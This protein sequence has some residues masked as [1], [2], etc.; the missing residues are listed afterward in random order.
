MA[1]LEDVP[2]IEV[3]ITVNGNDLKEYEED[4]IVNEPKTVTKYIEATSGVNFGIRYS[5]ARRFPMKGDCITFSM[6]L[7]NEKCGSS[8]VTK[9]SVNTS[10]SQHCK[11]GRNE[12][13]SKLR[14]FMFA[15]LETGL[16]FLDTS[17]GEPEQGHG[18][19]SVLRTEKVEE[20]CVATFIFRYRSLGGSPKHRCC[21]RIRK[22]EDL[23][24]NVV[25]ALKSL[26][27]IGRTP[28]PVPLEERPLEELSADQLREIIRQKV[29]RFTDD[30]DRG[31]QGSDH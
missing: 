3:A 19:R 10:S 27:I 28:T 20:A 30:N 24:G 17:L 12:A 31:N 26:R 15:A 7:D 13:D 14:R 6:Y 5:V 16:L 4:D 21:Q 29:S 22:C 9:A 11:Y 2:G 18:S 8:V 1:I 25:E 23:T